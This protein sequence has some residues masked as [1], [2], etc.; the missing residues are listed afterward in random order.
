MSRK[1]YGLALLLMALMAGRAGAESYVAHSG[2]GWQFEIRLDEVE[3]DTLMSLA[4]GGIVVDTHFGAIFGI[5]KGEYEAVSATLAAGTLTATLKGVSIW[6]VDSEMTGGIEL[7]TALRPDSDAFGVLTS[8]KEIEI[9][10]GGKTERFTLG[11]KPTAALKAF[12][13]K[14]G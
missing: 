4:C 2:R 6:S 1:Q 9:A 5:G 13:E 7:L 8:G 3:A 12:L 14:C 10:S 11:A